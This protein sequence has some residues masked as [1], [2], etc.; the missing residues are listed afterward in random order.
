MAHVTVKVMALFTVPPGVITVILP[1]V[2]PVGTLAT[3]FLP[4]SVVRC[5]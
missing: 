1:V 2:A 4:A 5:T 3:I